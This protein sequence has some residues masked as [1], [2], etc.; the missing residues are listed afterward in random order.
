MKKLFRKIAFVDKAIC[1]TR[2][3]IRL[4]R[5]LPFFSLFKKEPDRDSEIRELKKSLREYY[6]QKHAF[7]ESLEREITIE[8]M[9]ISQKERKLSLAQA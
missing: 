7:L 8:K 1:E 2:E 6:S 5:K 3:E 4:T 9:K